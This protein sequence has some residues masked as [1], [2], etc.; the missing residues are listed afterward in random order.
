MEDD[1]ENMLNFVQDIEGPSKK[2]YM[3]G[4]NKSE[5]ESDELDIG[6][7]ANEESGSKKNKYPI[8]KL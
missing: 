5:V 6:C 1:M 3:E 2:N 7:E 8:F 4:L